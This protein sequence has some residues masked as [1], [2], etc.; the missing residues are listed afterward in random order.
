MPSEA[1]RK[2]TVTA[3]RAEFLGRRS[4]RDSARRALCARAR[5]AEMTA[6]LADEFKIAEDA[7]GN[8]ELELE[9]DA[10][11]LGLDAGLAAFLMAASCV[12]CVAL[13]CGARRLCRMCR[14]RGY[15]S[16]DAEF[17]QV[18]QS[19]DDALDITHTIAILVLK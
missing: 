13:L 3:A 6:Q 10:V 11:D 8:V 5:V 12:I 1:F 9:A 15:G 18:G 16:V 14:R 2:A 19:F 7:V 17:G 4:H